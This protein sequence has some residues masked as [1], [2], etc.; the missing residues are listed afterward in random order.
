MNT[1]NYI[2]R[3]QNVIKNYLYPTSY[4]Y[5]FIFGNFIYIQNL[6]SAFAA[7]D[8]QNPRENL[9]KKVILKQL[10]INVSHSSCTM[11]LDVVW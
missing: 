5:T 3:T 4:M 6:A 10:S 8:S 11:G 7:S 9:D 2:S 1:Y